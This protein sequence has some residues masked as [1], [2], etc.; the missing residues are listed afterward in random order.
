MFGEIAGRLLPD[1]G[2][3]AVG[4]PCARK[5]DR[6]DAR[7]VKKVESE[8]MGVRSKRENCVFKSM[9]TVPT[10]LLPFYQ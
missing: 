4:C 8:A 2:M 10:S 1:L 7:K 3:L 9:S 5:K 6:N